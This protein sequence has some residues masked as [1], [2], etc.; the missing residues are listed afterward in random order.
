MNRR[1]GESSGIESPCQKS[2]LNKP[3]QRDNLSLPCCDP[4]LVDSIIHGGM[5]LQTA[6]Q[7][8]T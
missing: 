5:F 4:D 7:F 3:V 8:D 2:D 1:L 6:G